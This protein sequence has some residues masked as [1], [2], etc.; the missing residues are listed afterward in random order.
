M[1]G[2]AAD[3]AARG[4]QVDAQQSRQMI[5]Y[6]PVVQALAARGGFGDVVVVHLGTNGRFS[7]ATMTAFF[8][9]LAGVDRV[10]V[11][12][13]HAD[14]SW[15]NHNN[16]L[17]ATLPARYP[18]VTLVDWNTLVDSCE[19]NCLY[20]DGIHLPPAGRRFYAELIFA[21]IGI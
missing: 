15:T 12:T 5:E 16:E 14:R 19:G 18:N 3:L 2:A 1:L 17:L 10:I 4:V 21:T 13:V 9:A 8:D 7:E 11:L 20:D 6:L